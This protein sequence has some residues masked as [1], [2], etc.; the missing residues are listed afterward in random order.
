MPPAQA[1]KQEIVERLFTVFRDHGFDGASLAELSQA[2]GL[3]KSSLYHY[4]PGGKEEMAETVLS[5]A[6]SFIHSAIAEVAK[7]PLSLRARIRK[8]VAALEHLYEGGRTACVLGQLAAANIGDR[9][10]QQ[11][12]AAFASWIDATAQLAVESGMSQ[13]QAR[14]FAEDWVARLQ[15][16]LILQSAGRDTAAFKRTMSSLL[17]LAK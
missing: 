2:T 1:S 17:E 5:L 12:R 9:A 3:G 15:G 10:R 14:I 7:E 4:F 11:L 6:T 8:I 13:A 16:S